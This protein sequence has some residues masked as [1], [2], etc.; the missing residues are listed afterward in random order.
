MFHVF[1]I[2]QH[3][4]LLNSNPAKRCRT[5]Y[6]MRRVKPPSQPVVRK[7]GDEPEPTTEPDV[8]SDGADEIGEAMI[9][10]LPRTLFPDQPT[11]HASVTGA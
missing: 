7:P 11:S 10:D 9:R 5:T 8:P 2:N 6:T 4:K 3:Q 1:G